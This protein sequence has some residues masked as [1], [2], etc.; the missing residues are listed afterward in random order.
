MGGF[1]GTLE[2]S[3]VAPSKPPVSAESLFLSDEAQYIRLGQTRG[4][5]VL[6][7]QQRSSLG[8]LDLNRSGKK[9][10]ISPKKKEEERVNGKGCGST[11]MLIFLANYFL[12]IFQICFGHFF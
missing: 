6:L 12:I 1:Q 3:P 10:T 8:L 5:Q 7:R 11:Y 2:L 9:R 4:G